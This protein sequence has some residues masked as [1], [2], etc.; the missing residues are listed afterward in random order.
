M[1]P[2]WIAVSVIS[3]LIVLAVAIYLAMKPRKF[4]PK[5][6]AYWKEKAQ[7]MQ[8]RHAGQVISGG[9]AMG[10]TRARPTGKR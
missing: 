5:S 4:K 9:P 6:D 8:K 2:I 10:K 3:A 1:D 7:A